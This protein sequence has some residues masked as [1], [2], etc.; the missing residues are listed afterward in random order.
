[1]DS[2]PVS[3]RGK[4]SLI[5][6][7]NGPLLAASIHLTIIMHTVTSGVF[8]CAGEG[9]LLVK[10]VFTPALSCLCVFA[11][12]SCGPSL[13]K[14]SEGGAAPLLASGPASQQATQPLPPKELT[15]DLGGGVSMKLVL[16]PAGNLT[17]LR[18]GL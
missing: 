8:V 6:P 1:M 15:L 3:V 5:I 13:T 18:R 4:A 7:V 14:P 10:L 2:P 17:R 9:R 16:I 11:L 12:C